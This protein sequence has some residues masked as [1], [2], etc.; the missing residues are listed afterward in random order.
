MKGWLTVRS[1]PLLLS[2]DRYFFRLQWGFLSQYEGRRAEALH[3]YCIHAATLD[4]AETSRK[5]VLTIGPLGVLTAHGTD[6]VMRAGERGG[7]F[8]KRRKEEKGAGARMRAD[9]VSFTPARERKPTRLVLVADTVEEFRLWALLLERGRVR[10]IARRFLLR[11]AMGEGSAGQVFRATAVHGPFLEVAVKRVEYNLMREGA[12]ERNLRR[13]QKEVQTQVKAASRSPCVV[14]VLDVFFDSR[15]VYLVMEL[16]HGGSLREWLDDHGPVDDGVAV[17][18]AQQLTRCI[19]IL[20]Q[21][22]IVHRDVKTD[23]VLLEVDEN[24][25]MSGVRLTDFGFAEVCRNGDMN[26]FCTSFLGTASYM[27]TE[28]AWFDKYGAPVDMYALGVLCF[29][30]LTGQYPFDA[31][32]GLIDQI[33]K[34]KKADRTPIIDDETLTP[35]AKSFCLALTNE[36]PRKRLIAAAALQHRWLRRGR[37]VTAEALTSPTMN[38]GGKAWFRRAFHVI[39]A[40]HAMRS[41]TRTS[42]PVRLPLSPDVAED[43]LAMLRRLDSKNIPQQPVPRQFVDFREEDDGEVFV[44]DDSHS[45]L[46]AL[47]AR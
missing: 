14:N 3:R 21:N 11:E 13:L 31:D 34:I 4:L 5:I 35:D 32:G 46:G 17:S 30:V 10:P 25:N 44:G 1:G 27:A 23:N 42:R 38:R 28:I 19:L 47:L 20:H 8:S 18:I 6:R 29:V 2:A 16:V 9:D 15:Y 45:G 37:N 24:G 43:R 33:A 36:D 22:H 7:F 12:A 39:S 41:F 40:V 26:T